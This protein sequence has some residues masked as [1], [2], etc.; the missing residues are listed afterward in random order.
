MQNLS[1]ER[2]VSEG[3]FQETKCKQIAKNTNTAYKAKRENS[4]R[5]RGLAAYL[6]ITKQIFASFWFFMQTIYAE[7]EDFACNVH[8]PHLTGIYSTQVWKRRDT[9]VAFTPNWCGA[10]KRLKSKRKEA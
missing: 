9:S 8:R 2:F 6:C 7:R 1:S 3:Q 4:E 5:E 10:K